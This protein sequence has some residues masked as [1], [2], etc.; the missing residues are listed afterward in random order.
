MLKKPRAPALRGRRRECEVLDQL[1]ASLRA[2]QSQTLV[3]CGEAGI[4][5]T[6]L[7]DYLAAESSDCRIERVTGVEPEMELAFAGVHQL[8]APMLEHLDHLPEPQRDAVRTAFGLDTGDVPDRFLLGLA[9]LRL[10]SDAA[11]DRPLICIID[12]VQWMDRASVQLLAFVARRML[13]EAVAL[14]FTIREHGEGR[15]L[16]GL[17]EMKLDG[18]DDENARDLLDSAIQGRLDERVRD[19]ILA[20]ARGNPLAL[21][22]LPRGLTAAELAGG[23]ALPDS[24]PLASRT[25][26]SFIRQFALLPLATQR[27]LRVAAAEPV[28]DA[29]LLWRAAEKLGITADA[30]GPAEAAG[31]I[32]FGSRVRFRHPLLRSAVYRAASLSERQMIHRAL[33]DATDPAVDPDRRAWH[34]AG[35]VAGHDESVAEELQQSAGRAQSRGGIAAAAAFLERA[36]AVTPDPERRAMRS[37]AAAQA[38][39]D[40]GAP[41]SA[42]KLLAE[43]EIGPL[44]ELQTAMLARLRAQIVFARTHGRDAPTLL[45]HAARQLEHLDGALS[46]ETYLEALGARIIAGRLGG[47]PGRHEV[48]EAALAAPPAELPAQPTDLLLDAVATRFKHGYVAAVAPLKR[49]LLAFQQ[50]AERG[51]S[52]ALR[53]LWLTCPIAPG[54]IPLE[55]WDDG[56][57]RDLATDVVNIAR[58][59]GALA[60]LPIALG[61]R[62]GLHVHAGEFGEA[63][64]L[65]EE[66]SAI[67][68]ATGNAPVWHT[69]L[70]LAAWRGDEAHALDLIDAGVRDAMAKGEGRT[71]GFVGYAT[72]VLYNGLG[73]YE[74][75]LAGAQRGCDDDDLGF[76][77]WTLVELIEAAARLGARDVATAAFLQLEE[78]TSAAGTDWA[79][80]TGARARAL[81]SEGAEAE[82]LYRVAIEK[83]ERCDIAVHLARAHLVYGEWLRRENRRVDAREQLR[84]AYE[85][86]DSMGAGAFAE[87]ARREL[88][89]TGETVRRRT[90]ETRDLLTAQETQVARLAAEGRTNPEIGSQLFIS[91]RTAEYH[92]HKV[93]AKLGIRSR[94]GLRG[95]LRESG[96]TAAQA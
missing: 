79:L 55:L 7:L 64:A 15:A 34:R 83:F 60:A 87:R 63:S 52:D 62:A 68:Q 40:A 28:G 17:P 3:L 91:P 31:F 48:A 19:R 72:G 25:E 16:A 32:E 41:D 74:A 80:G 5:K 81:L 24:A 94:R 20:E 61:Y 73:R 69:T 47:R 35:A 4:G 58:E 57:W 10:L 12:D 33:A 78:R 86:L 22:E 76:F 50:Q 89:A 77:G 96:R 9:L 2:G 29:T 18:L 90:V 56:T 66:A 85:M 13:A 67:T 26:Q 1:L 38:K 11:E 92:L 95:A 30:A 49:A 44:T 37:L 39:F 45:F 8:C 75:A 43:A 23:F 84:I 82:R 70:A 54:P 21:L 27:L 88:L 59:A 65:M 71:I 14:V 53:C 51:E 46:R 6:A 36:A 93:F 42:Y